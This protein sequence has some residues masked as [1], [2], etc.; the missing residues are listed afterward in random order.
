MP[1]LSNGWAAGRLLLAV[2]EDEA[3]LAVTRGQRPAKHARELDH[4]RGAGGAVVGADEA[5]RV[6]LGVVVGADH[7]RGAGTGQGADDVAQPAAEG[8]EAAVGQ[9]P[10]KLSREMPQLRRPGGALAD[11]DLALDLLE[12]ALGVEAVDRVGR[13]AGTAAAADREEGGGNERC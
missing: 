7:Q 9:H 4:R 5:L 10:A 6:G 11:G 8:L 2:E 3:D 12:G 1:H 13:G